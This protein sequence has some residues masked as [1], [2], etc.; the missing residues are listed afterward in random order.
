[1]I[2]CPNCS[3][4]NLDGI[5]YCD[6]C[7][8]PLG[9]GAPVATHPVASASS[10]R[11]IA[12][13]Y[14][15]ERELGGGGQKVMYLAA[16][17]RLSERLCALAELTPSARSLQAIAE[18]KAMFDREAQI[19][20][21]LSNIHVVQVYDY[22]NEGDRCYLVEEYVRGQT[23][24]QRIASRSR[25]GVSE[26]NEIALQVLDAL[27]YLHGQTPPLVHRDLKPDNIMLAPAS[28]GAEVVK[29]I[30][31]GIARHFQVQRGTVHGTP[32]YA[33]PEQ[34]RGMSEPRTDL[35][36]LGGILHYALS[37]RD[38]QEHEP[39]SFPPL[40]S[41]RPD[42]PKALC[43][44]IDQ[45]L[46]NEADR[47]PPDAAQFK[48]RLIAATSAKPVASHT[49]H[50]PASPP[51]THPAAR[52][53]HPPRPQPHS[54][55]PPPPLPP[56]LS[57]PSGAPQPQSAV[58]VRSLSTAAILL[59]GGL[60][61]GG[62]I[63]LAGRDVTVSGILH[64]TALAE[65]REA[66]N[67]ISTVGMVALLILLIASRRRGRGATLI[68]G[69][70][71]ISVLHVAVAALLV[72]YL[73]FPV[74]VAGLALGSGLI[75]RRTCIRLL[76]R[77]GLGLGARAR[78]FFILMAPPAAVC[79]AA[80][81]LAAASPTPPSLSDYQ[82][83]PRTPP[84]YAPARI[85]AKPPATRPA[86]R[87]RAATHPRRTARSPEFIESELRQNLA[88]NGFPNV[89]VSVDSAGRAYINGS[90]P[91][92]TQKTE[93]ENVVRGVAGVR[94]VVSKIDVPRGWMGLSVKSGGGGA[95]VSYLARGGPAERAGIMQDD[96]IVAI[97]GRTVG[98][99]ADFRDAI[100]AKAAGQTVTVT[101]VRDGQTLD[102]P[103]KLASKQ[104]RSG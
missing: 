1:M 55:P 62:E 15:I 13:R 48:N 3:F 44:L 25:L 56:T 33:A 89:G 27:E 34:Y 17:L 60:A 67:L 64:G 86:I 2:K 11:V 104:S 75:L 46:S 26:I 41:I 24:Q 73:L 8:D 29:L 38:P 83:E 28:G 39:F 35:Y 91:D 68:L 88:G 93:I 22:F 32:G 87:Y 7:G 59:T 42:L 31:F 30:D 50:P 78:A 96:V 57:L 66:A 63:L 95:L 90:A 19:L 103:V 40:E 45:A 36:A 81:V 98:N 14:R 10:G 20:A 4:E 77:S 76:S 49:P 23:L 5:A 16:D 97:D 61:L 79:A 12:G 51:R 37:G 9:A 69:L 58:V 99:H 85:A 47:R 71:A 82:G 72:D 52:G 101:L 100:A 74:L 54:L 84:P 70:I 92:F 102:V 6:S 53:H 21:T 65:L 18:G 43:T 94:S 80:L